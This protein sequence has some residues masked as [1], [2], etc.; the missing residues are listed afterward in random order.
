MID[1]KQ[2]RPEDFN[3][4]FEGEE[5]VETA[6]HIQIPVKIIHR[7][8]GETAFS[9]MVSIRADFYRE[10]KEQTGHF[11]ALVKIVN[12]RCREAILQRMHSKQMDVSDKL[13][14]IYMEENPIQ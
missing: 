7:D 13:E 10:L 11:Q 9:K 5:I 12:R 14:M 1:W 4:S 3:C 2:V 8:S 6:T